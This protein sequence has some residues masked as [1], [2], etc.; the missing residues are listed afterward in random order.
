MIR[1][2]ES[3]HTSSRLY[4]RMPSDAGGEILH[5]LQGLYNKKAVRPD[6]SGGAS[7]CKLRASLARPIPNAIHVTRGQGSGPGD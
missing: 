1:Q 7:D 6:A 4:V 5:F 3:S 2:N